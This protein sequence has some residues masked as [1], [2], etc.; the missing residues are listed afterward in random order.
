MMRGAENVDLAELTITKI[1]DGAAVIPEE[2]LYNNTNI[3]VITV[4]EG[5]V[6]IAGLIDDTYTLREVSAPAGDI[7]TDSG[8][9]FKTE[10]GAI[11]NSDNTAHTNEAGVYGQ[12]V[13][14]RDSGIRKAEDRSFSVCR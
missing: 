1:S 14:N 13:T 12:E 7:I 11:K 10:N 5:G 2:Y 6:K 3:T 8:K 9:T 4:P